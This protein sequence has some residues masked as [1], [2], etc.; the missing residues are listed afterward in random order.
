MNPDV[1]RA[2]ASLP[3]NAQPP[4]DLVDDATGVQVHEQRGA[5]GQIVGDACF[6][7]ALVG[8]LER[9]A[10][11][12]DRPCERAAAGQTTGAKLARGRSLLGQ[13]REAAQ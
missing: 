6:I 12:D 2:V 1:E 13:L 3:A 4:T 10:W 11:H 7:G 8:D 9:R 5:L